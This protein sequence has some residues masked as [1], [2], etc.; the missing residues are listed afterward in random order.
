MGAEG[1][2]LA[3]LAA[4]LASGGYREVKLWRRQPMKAQRSIALNSDAAILAL[5]YAEGSTGPA[6]IFSCP[7]PYR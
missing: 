5:K 2:G 1:A 7:I 6:F 3:G 4:L